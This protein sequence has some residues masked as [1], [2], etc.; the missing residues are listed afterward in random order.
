M[1]PRPADAGRGVRVTAGQ[2]QQSL[3]SVVF[4][5]PLPLIGSQITAAVRN[6]TGFFDSLVDTAVPQ[7]RGDINTAIAQ[8][9]ANHPEL[10][11]NGTHQRPRP[12]RRQRIGAGEQQREAFPIPP[13]T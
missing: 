1:W 2:L 6:A 4:V 5:N 7:L 3:G 12:Q 13:A 11:A 10:A 9:S 8:G